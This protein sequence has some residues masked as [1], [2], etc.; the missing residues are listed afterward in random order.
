MGK[1]IKL[2]G[3]RDLTLWNVESFTVHLTSTLTEQLKNI[4]KLA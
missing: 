1:Q 3:M 4:R 2:S